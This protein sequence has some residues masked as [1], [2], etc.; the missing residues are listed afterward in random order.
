MKI[1]LDPASGEAWVPVASGAGQAVPVTPS[2]R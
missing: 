2:A 1:F